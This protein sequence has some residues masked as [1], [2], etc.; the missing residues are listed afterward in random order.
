MSNNNEIEKYEKE[1]NERVKNVK[2]E[3]ITE[4]DNKIDTFLN[5]SALKKI[6]DKIKTL[7]NI[8][9]D[10]ETPW[11]YKAVAIAALIYLI[12]PIDLIPDAFP[13]IGFL[14]DISIIMIAYNKIM[15][16]AN[17]LE[18]KPIQNEENDN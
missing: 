2:E 1:L 15:E 16:A 5:I 9:K 18:D 13:I 17:T 11:E 10:S 6:K 7:Y 4:I 12:S 8:I 14:D 3:D